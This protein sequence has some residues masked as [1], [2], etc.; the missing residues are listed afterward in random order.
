MCKTTVTLWIPVLRAYKRCLGLMEV[1]DRV[2]VEALRVW[3]A[4]G[5]LVVL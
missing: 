4:T 2:F 5:A 3:W 1:R